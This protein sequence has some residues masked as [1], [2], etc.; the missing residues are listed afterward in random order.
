MVEVGLV[1]PVR[2]GLGR[3]S[4]WRLLLDIPKSISS[5]NFP[6]KERDELD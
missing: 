4:L 3:R 1:W 2:W 6:E 5:K